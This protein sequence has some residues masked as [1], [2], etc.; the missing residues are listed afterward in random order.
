MRCQG[1]A[2]SFACGP[3]WHNSK[4]REIRSHF[5]WLMTQ[6]HGFYELF[7]TFSDCFPW[8]LEL[9]IDYCLHFYLSVINTQTKI[10]E[11]E[12]ISDPTRWRES[13]SQL[14]HNRIA[15][16]HIIGVK[17][18]HSVKNI[19]FNL[20][21]TRVESFF[22]FIDRRRVKRLWL[23]VC[24]QVM[25]EISLQFISFPSFLHAQLIRKSGRQVS[26]STASTG[27]TLR[28]F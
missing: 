28:R 18:D 3:D 20:L 8:T 4:S 12:F 17:I 14:Q 25:H 23:I 13:S 21:N 16:V 9:H 24:N 1:V 5:L 22:F 6:C 27:K 2:G 11:S 26:S 19:P 7:L 15:H 10:L